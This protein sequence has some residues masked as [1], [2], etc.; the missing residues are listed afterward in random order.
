M[1]RS[2][3]FSQ[4]IIRVDARLCDPRR[5]P[6]L[7]FPLHHVASN[8][9]LDNWVRLSITLAFADWQIIFQAYC[10]CTY[11]SMYL[12]SVGAS[13]LH[14]LHELF[15]E[16]VKRGAKH[17][18]RIC[19]LVFL[20]LCSPAFVHL[21]LCFL[22]SDSLMSCHSCIWPTFCICPSPL[23]SLVISFSQRKC[24]MGYNRVLYLLEPSAAVR[25]AAR[26]GSR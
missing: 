23:L 22:F 18:T 12:T 24:H 11:S 14:R 7:F 16:N 13:P 10:M 6:C 19:S 21:F 8:L 9:M 26:G 20:F 15:G 17:P 3:G 5:G 2:A 25:S 1:E 4:R